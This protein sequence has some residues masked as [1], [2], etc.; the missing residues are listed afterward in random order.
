[1]L[2]ICVKVKM[3]KSQITKCSELTHFSEDD[4]YKTLN[5][6]TKLWCSTPSI[7]PT[8]LEKCLIN[9]FEFLTIIEQRCVASS[10]DNEIQ[11]AFER[12]GSKVSEE[13]SK[14]TT[15]ITSD[16]GKN[17]IAEISSVID[18]TSKRLDTE[19]KAKVFESTTTTLKE[20]N[21][22]TTQI[23]RM[24]GELGSISG[25]MSVA[26]QT[27]TLQTIS[28]NLQ[29]LTHEFKNSLIKHA[30][31]NQEKGEEGE[32]FV[33]TQL[34][35]LLPPT[36]K[37]TNMSKH[38]NE[39]DLQVLTPNKLLIGIDVKNWS[40][41][42]HSSETIKSKLLM[43]NHATMNIGIVAS[44]CSKIEIYDQP[45]YELRGKNKML[46]MFPHIKDHMTN[47]V[48]FI[49]AC[50]AFS[51]CIVDATTCTI[52]S[53]GMI[54]SLAPKLYLIVERMRQCQDDD[55]GLRQ[56]QAA[57]NYSKQL[58]D[59]HKIKFNAFVE[60]YMTILRD[61]WGY[62]TLPSPVDV[63]NSQLIITSQNIHSTIQYPSDAPS[64]VPRKRGRPQGS[65]TKNVTKILSRSPVS[66]PHFAYED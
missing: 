18:V 31:P 46:W 58:F 48:T 17:V 20:M 15:S 42:V 63:G 49:K 59:A 45:T 3:D 62:Y 22:L 39:M 40:Y 27:Q 36:Y 2:T 29:T 33:E 9:I 1:M 56:I 55:M 32:R 66:S 13:L 7:T 4:I 24:R 53:N 10:S 52:H 34:K 25:Q 6:L 37:V 51:K 65:G 61:E 44:L 60:E 23:E 12:F 26:Q 11:H 35:Q 38:S 47:L 50:D 19:M 64:S 43:E 28:S 16:V 30:K 5:T 57:L 14:M 8:V 21:A 41:P 54:N